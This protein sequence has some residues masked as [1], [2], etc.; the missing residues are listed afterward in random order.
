M[1]MQQLLD[2][3]KHLDADSL[4]Q[5]R[6]QIAQREDELRVQQHPQTAQEWREVIDEFL[7]NFWGDTPDEEQEAIVDAIRIKNI[8]PNRDV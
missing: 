1:D 7:D 5:L 4:L 8:P 3:V 2:A 6:Q